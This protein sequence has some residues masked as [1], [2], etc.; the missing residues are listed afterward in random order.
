LRCTRVRAVCRHGAGT[1][2]CDFRRRFLVPAGDNPYHVTSWLPMPQALQGQFGL[3]ATRIEWKGREM[4]LP[5]RPHRFTDIGHTDWRGKK[6]P[7]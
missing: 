6:S 7:E 5:S 4:F 2:L 3:N 1:A